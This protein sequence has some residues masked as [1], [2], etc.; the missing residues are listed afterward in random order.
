MK[1]KTTRLSICE[2]GFPTLHEK[3]G[4]GTEYSITPVG[5][6]FTFI[7]GGCHRVH[8]EIKGVHAVRGDYSGYLPAAI[9]EPP[10]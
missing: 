10:S 7:C 4:L 2:C 1:A 9:F 5:G 3:L 6:T 8:Y